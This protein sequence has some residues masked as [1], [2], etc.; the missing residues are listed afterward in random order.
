MTANAKIL[1]VIFSC[2]KLIVRTVRCMAGDAGYL[3]IWQGWIFRS[4]IIF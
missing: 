4:N 3:S 2:K 1:H